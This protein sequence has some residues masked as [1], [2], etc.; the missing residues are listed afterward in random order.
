[1]SSRETVATPSVVAWLEVSSDLR[2]SNGICPFSCVPLW[3]FGSS[4]VFCKWQVVHLHHVVWSACVGVCE[5]R[6]VMGEDLKCIYIDLTLGARI[7][8]WRVYQAVWTLSGQV[9]HSPTSHEAHEVIFTLPCKYLFFLFL[10][11]LSLTLWFCN[12]GWFQH[13]WETVLEFKRGDCVIHTWSHLHL[14]RFCVPY[15]LYL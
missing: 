9:W 2:L 8:S 13:S 6:D 5:P 10:F 1:M 7:E 11:F 15:T 12:F 4:V 3:T 14:R